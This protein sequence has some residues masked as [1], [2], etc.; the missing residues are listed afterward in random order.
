MR[1]MQ[2]VA[3]A[4]LAGRTAIGARMPRLKDDRGVAAVEF[5]LIAPVMI[6]LYLSTVVTTQAYMASRKVALVARALSDVAS[7]K[8]VGTAGCTPTTT[9]NPCVSNSDIT[10]FFDAAALIMAPYSITPLKM[11]LSRIDVVQDTGSS[12]KLSS[13]TLHRGRATRAA[14]FA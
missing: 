14:A 1:A 11:T 4:F 10:N 2:R 9:G 12:P 8:T 6:V 3:R 5:A 13:H 7:R